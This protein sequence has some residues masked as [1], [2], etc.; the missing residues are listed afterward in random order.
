MRGRNH[1]DSHIEDAEMP[2]KVHADQMSDKRPEEPSFPPPITQENFHAD[3][4]ASLRKRAQIG[5]V[6]TNLITDTPV[7][8]NDFADSQMSGFGIDNIN[9][10]N[11]E[12]D[13][14]K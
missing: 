7:G 6:R 13:Q 8:P 2:K 14:Q 12:F 1:N 5:E 3:M 11:N 4:L 10:R 9:N